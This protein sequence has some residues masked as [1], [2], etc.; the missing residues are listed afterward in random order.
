MDEESELRMQYLEEKAK[1]EFIENSEWS[2]VMSM[3]SEEEQKELED[4]YDEF[5]ADYEKN[6]LEE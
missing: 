2:C 3:L 1:K 5:G 4:L 6:K